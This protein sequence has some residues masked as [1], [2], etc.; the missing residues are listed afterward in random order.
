MTELDFTNWFNSLGR[1]L[2]KIS[3]KVINA[4]EHEK[5]SKEEINLLKLMYPYYKN[6]NI[7]F[8]KNNTDCLKMTIDP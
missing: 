7:M 2:Q 5:L 6:E 3:D 8:G 4:K 1:R